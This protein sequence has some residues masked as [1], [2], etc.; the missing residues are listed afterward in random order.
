MLTIFFN[1]RRMRAGW[2]IVIFAG[3]L[4]FLFSLFS[5]PVLSKFPNLG[6]PLAQDL[7]GQQLLL[8]NGYLLLPLILAS[9]VMA[10]YVDRRPFASLGFGFCRYLLR[11]LFSGVLL[12]FLMISIFFLFEISTGLIQAGW[13][14]QNLVQLV[15]NLALCLLGFLGA[16]AFEEILFRGYAFQTLIEGIGIYP[17]LFLLSIIFSL[18]HN[19]N[20]HITLLGLVNIGLAGLLLSTAY[21]KAKSLWFPIGVHFSW[22][23]FQ[24]SIYSLPVSGLGFSAKLLEVEPTG[25]Q[26]LTGGSFGPEG[27]FITTIIFCAAIALI[28]FYKRVKPDE[29]METLW[30]EHI[31]P[32]GSARF[33]S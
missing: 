20:P 16:A 21:L 23:F 17:S 24:S 15:K 13:A 30:N 28:L 9:L 26:Y 1:K 22:N 25:P 32:A 4:L 2:R 11:E 27:S 5:I 33:I 29:K 7:P 8:L 14:G 19:A 10:K 6:E 3:L 18:W 12:G 31:Y